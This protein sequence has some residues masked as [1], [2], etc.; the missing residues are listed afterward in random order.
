MESS[1]LRIED[2]Q[3]ELLRSVS[4]MLVGMERI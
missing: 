2:L 1:R 4:Y 3:K